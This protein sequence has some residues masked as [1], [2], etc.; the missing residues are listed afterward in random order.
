MTQPLDL[1][2]IAARIA[3]GLIAY[4]LRELTGLLGSAVQEAIGDDPAVPEDGTV[5]W[6]DLYDAVQKRLRDAGGLLAEVT[7]LRAELATVEARIA[8]VVALPT[9]TRAELEQMDREGYHQAIGYSGALWKVK[10]ALTTAPTTQE[11]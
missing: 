8:T 7:R 2:A 10:H 4:A 9:A 5:A 11:A 6:D 3:D 1:D